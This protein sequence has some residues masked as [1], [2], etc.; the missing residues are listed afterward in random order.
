[1]SL[2]HKDQAVTFISYAQNF[3]DVLL[4][5]ALK[6]VLRGNYLDIGAYDPVS[7]SVSLAFHQLGWRGVHVEPQLRYSTA[8]TQH[9]PGDVVLQAA[10]GTAEGTITMH[11]VGDG[12]GIT[13]CSADV[14]MQHQQRG[15]PVTTS[16]VPCVRLATILDGFGSRDIHWMKIDV[17]GLEED[18]IRS[19]A[20]NTVRPWIVVVES[21]E[22]LSPTPNHQSWEP[23][24][25][26]YGYQFV[27]FDGLN[28]YYVSDKH[29]ELAASFSCGPNYFDDFKVNPG[30]WILPETPVVED[31][32]PEPAPRRDFY[33]KYRPRLGP[34]RRKVRAWLKK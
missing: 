14:A 22:P 33:D 5:R 23:V 2:A 31:K 28:R 13:T 15:Y 20:G 24:L 1:L 10:V 6:H 17:E 21:T 8:L 3:E 19:W 12:F 30:H 4:H 32:K 7:D 26:G 27:H 16:I 34:L 25:L 11:E 18:V 9:R 29:P